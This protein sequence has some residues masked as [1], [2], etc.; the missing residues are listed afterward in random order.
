MLGF[1]L[2]GW[3]INLTSFFKFVTFYCICFVELFLLVLESNFGL[4]ILKK[5][6][7]IDAVIVTFEACLFVFETGPHVLSIVQQDP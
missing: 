1:G 7:K 6:K 5:K 3:R 2:E 4:S